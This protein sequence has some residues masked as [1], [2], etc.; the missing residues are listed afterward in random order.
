MYFV[1]QK[2]GL[3]EAMCIV[4]VRRSIVKSEKTMPLISRR[5]F[6][7]AMMFLS[8]K[9]GYIKKR[10]G[11]VYSCTST[12]ICKLATMPAVAAATALVS[13]LMLQMSLASML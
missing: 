4:T 1:T 10:R 6:G 5:L 3:L 9:W 12:A 7:I 8:L 13:I 2:K 11:W